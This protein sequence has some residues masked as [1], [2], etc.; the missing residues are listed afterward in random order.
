VSYYTDVALNIVVHV[1]LL[2]KM[3]NIFHYSTGQSL[4]PVFINLCET[5][6]Q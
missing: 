2:Y 4:R 6:V 1:V 5:T 3:V